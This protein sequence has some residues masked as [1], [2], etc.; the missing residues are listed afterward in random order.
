VS[1]IFS[2]KTGTLTQNLMEFKK[3]S[4]GGVEYGRGFC[5]V[6]RAIAR[7]Q[8]RRSARPPSPPPPPPPGLKR[9]PSSGWTR[10][11]MR[12]KAGLL[13]VRPVAGGTAM[14]PSGAR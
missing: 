8:G 12:A 5:E 13:R 4:I 7:R 3:C 6:E 2:D 1:Y 11:R 14:P 10:L 9:A